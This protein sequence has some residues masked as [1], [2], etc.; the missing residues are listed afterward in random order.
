[1]IRVCSGFSPA[2][3]VQYGERFLAS[4][5][6]HWPPDIQLQVYVEDAGQSGPMVERSLWDIPGARA[7]H[8][9][10]ADNLSAQGRTQQPCWKD[11]ERSRG[12]SFRTDA[13][14]FWKQI[15]IP[16]AA[17]ADM[18]DGDILVWLDG[19]VETTAPVPL[20]FVP[21]MLGVAEVSYLGRARGHSEI[22][23]WAVRLNDRTRRFLSD[24]AEVYRTDHVFELREWHSAFV[25]DHIRSRSGLVERN[26]C[27][28]GTVG[29]VWP[30][31]PLARYMRHD[32]GERKPRE[33]KR[34]DR[35]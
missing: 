1:M 31:S 15:L 17:A 30:L 20:D 24:I 3:R 25:W 23:F 5:N 19:D 4:F 32:K 14:K 9:R 11:K 6:R 22:G 18:A 2:G 8:D 13:Y 26:I 35:V 7:F 21:K 12:Y 16:E 10:H 34:L 27:R 28:P 29:H 33:E